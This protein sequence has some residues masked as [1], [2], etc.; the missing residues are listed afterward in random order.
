MKKMILVLVCAMLAANAFAA[1]GK[2]LFGKQQKQEQQQE[3]KE[4]ESA[5]EDSF[6]GQLME[7]LR[8]MKPGESWINNIKINDGV[9]W[10]RIGQL[11]TRVGGGFIVQ[12]YNAKTDYVTEPQRK[13]VS[14]V[15]VLS[16][17]F[18]SDKEMFGQ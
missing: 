16:S 2:K 9:G 17:L 4:Q 3:Q 13:L 8:A 12:T 6:N 18:V 1:G 15:R 14:E 11:Y 10:H 5:T 7:K